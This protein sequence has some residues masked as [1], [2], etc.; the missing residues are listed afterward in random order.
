MAGKTG[1]QGSHT[2]GE[3]ERA[4]GAIQYL[5]RLGLG[6]S[7]SVTPKVQVNPQGTVRGEAGTSELLTSNSEPRRKSKTT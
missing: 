5:S 3:V 4:V 7:D 2:S 1:D 6:S